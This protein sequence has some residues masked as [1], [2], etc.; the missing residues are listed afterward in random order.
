LK[1]TVLGKPVQFVSDCIGEEAKMLLQLQ[2][3]EVL[4]WKTYV[5]IKR[6]KQEMLLLQ[7]ISFTW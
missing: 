4:C 2:A 3:G 6:K 7:R 1:T 5:F